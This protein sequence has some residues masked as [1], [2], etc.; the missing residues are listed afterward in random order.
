[1]SLGNSPGAHPVLGRWPHG[2]RRSPPTTGSLDAFRLLTRELSGE[3]GTRRQPKGEE[4]LGPGQERPTDEGRL[5]LEHSA[6]RIR[7]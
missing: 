6:P 1:M 7:V 2:L 4:Y 3:S 5:P